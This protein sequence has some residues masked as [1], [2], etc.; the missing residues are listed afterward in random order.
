MILWNIQWH[1]VKNYDTMENNGTISKT[2]ELW[3]TME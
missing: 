3:F 1:Y 2:M